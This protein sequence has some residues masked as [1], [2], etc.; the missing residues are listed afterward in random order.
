MDSDD[1][2]EPVT[3]NTLKDYLML[4]WAITAPGCPS[5]T[6]VIQMFSIDVKKT[7]GQNA[8]NQIR[9]TIHYFRDKKVRPTLKEFRDQK[10]K[11]DQIYF[12]DLPDEKIDH[13][14]QES[15]DKA[16][17]ENL[18]IPTRIVK[19][20]FMNIIN[21][22]D[23]SAPPVCF[24]HTIIKNFPIAYHNSLREA[25]QTFAMTARRQPNNNEIRQILGGTTDGTW[26]EDN[27]AMSAAIVDIRDPLIPDSEKNNLWGLYNKIEDDQRRI[28]ERNKRNAPNE[29][30]QTIINM[31]HIPKTKN[32]EAD[33]RLKE[34]QK[35]YK[36]EFWTHSGSPPQTWLEY[37]D[38]N[39]G[40]PA[41]QLAN[42]HIHRSLEMDDTPL[43]YQR[44]IDT[45]D[46]E[47]ADADPNDE[48][49]Q[50]YIVNTVQTICNDFIKKLKESV[51]PYDTL[52]GIKSFTTFK[53]SNKKRSRDEQSHANLDETCSK[54]KKVLQNHSDT[55]FNWSDP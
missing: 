8:A 32:P 51:K 19:N 47:Y 16:I 41:D 27:R 53:L 29:K 54:R 21:A 33:K 31:R 55:D 9:K 22:E 34:L 43:N 44:N 20:A 25:A 14:L 30:Q 10:R 7:D 46:D 49:V 38:M 52:K 39:V 45:L 4:G 12:H 15:F 24:N 48:V 35:Y 42:L 6:M 2:D 18:R 1:D 13:H 26:Y 36:K 28:R 23:S 40:D 5:T 37:S 17:Q 50:N 11:I 3:L